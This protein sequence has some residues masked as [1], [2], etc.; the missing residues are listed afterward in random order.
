MAEA[1]VLQ[2]NAQLLKAIQANDWAEY[3]RL[4]DPSVTCIEAETQ[5]QIVEGLPFHQFFFAQAPY[6]KVSEPQADPPEKHTTMA[7]PHV[8]LI[9]DSCAVVCYARLIQSK[10]GISC[11]Q[12][13]RVWQRGPDHAWRNVHTHRSKL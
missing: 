12:E 3:A 13:T 6:G 9:G 7:S 1:E 5:G 10:S 11:S 4:S 8:R 2:C